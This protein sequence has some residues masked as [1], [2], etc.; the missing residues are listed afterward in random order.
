MMGFPAPYLH[1]LGTP[2]HPWSPESGEKKKENPTTHVHYIGYM[3]EKNIH[4]DFHK[5]DK[6]SL[7]ESYR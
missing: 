6:A 2:S 7:E 3:E 5:T 4:N 1:P